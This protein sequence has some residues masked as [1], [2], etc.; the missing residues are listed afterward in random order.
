[1]AADYNSKLIDLETKEYPKTLSDLRYKYPDTSFSTTVNDET[2]EH[3]QFAE[4]V[5][6]AKPTGDVVTEGTPVLTDGV[7]TQVWEVRSFTEEE[8][9]TQLE[10]AKAAA[11]SKVNAVRDYTI[12]LGVPYDFDGVTEHVQFENDDRINLLVLESSASQLET[13][14][15][16]S[17]GFRTKENT[18]H[19]LTAGDTIT[20]CQ[21]VKEWYSSLLTLTWGLK[22]QISGSATK[23]EL[24]EIPEVFVI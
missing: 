19:Q 12:S 22:T 4:V 10:S 1:M 8:L 6:V 18:V 2:L 13:D 9:S 24:P 14:A 16:M 23:E 21:Y 15:V 5:R 17:P 20:L 3:F 7:W 11:L